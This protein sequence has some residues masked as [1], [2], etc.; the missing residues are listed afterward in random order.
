MLVH[1]F[2]CLSAR[3]E[4]KFEFE[5]NRLSGVE[6]EIERSGVRKTQTI[7]NQPNNPTRSAHSFPT[8]PNL[9]ASPAHHLLFFPSPRVQQL[10]RPSIPQPS[11]PRAS[12]SWLTACATD[13]EWPIG[14]RCLLPLYFL[15]PCAGPTLLRTRYTRCPWTSNSMSPTSQPHPALSFQK[16]HHP[17]R[18]AQPPGCDP[19]FLRSPIPAAISAEITPGHNCPR[20]RHPLLSSPAALRLHILL[21]RH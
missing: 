9:S 18:I 2:I 6:I 10:T 21:P 20:S 11:K 5:F 8:G 1:C 15:L 13:R 16:C 7:S 17:S 12:P 3:V 14:Q 19:F 4:F